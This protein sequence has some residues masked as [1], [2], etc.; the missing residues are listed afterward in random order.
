MDHYVEK[1]EVELAKK[2]SKF[3]KQYPLIAKR[4]D[5]L[6]KMAHSPCGLEG[7]DLYQPLI[8]RIE[9]LEKRRKKQK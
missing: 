8:D 9:A 7:F 1:E 6:E 2:D 5:E 4:L 3:R